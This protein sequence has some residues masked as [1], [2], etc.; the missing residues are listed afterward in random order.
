MRKRKIANVKNERKM[1]SIVD[2]L[3]VVHGFFHH[4]FHLILV[5]D[6]V[7]GCDLVINIVAL[8]P[9]DI[10]AVL[11]GHP[12]QDIEEVLFLYDVKRELL[13]GIDLRDDLFDTTATGFALARVCLHLVN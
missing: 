9:Y 10:E 2:W 8:L 6:A 1:S 13:L 12:V 4:D 5:E 11:N 7:P 3:K